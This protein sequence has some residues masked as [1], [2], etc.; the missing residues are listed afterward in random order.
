MEDKNLLLIF[1]VLIVAIFIVNT[2]SGTKDLTG[3]YG[4]GGYTGAYKGERGAMLC[5]EF[6]NYVKVTTGANVRD[7]FNACTHGGD[8]AKIYYCDGNR[9]AFREQWCPTGYKCVSGGVCKP[10]STA[11]KYP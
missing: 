2:F 5:E 3:R 8:K 10:D 11:T 4:S 9:V 7:Y 1:I 6:G